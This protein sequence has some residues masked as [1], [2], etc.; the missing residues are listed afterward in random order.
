MCKDYKNKMLE[1]ENT[2]YGS[3]SKL[4]IQRGK[5]SKLED[6]ALEMNKNKT[7]NKKNLKNVL[8]EGVGQ[9]HAAWEKGAEGI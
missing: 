3:N 6:T 5:T 7:K 9:L 1:K 2:P 4:A 8:K